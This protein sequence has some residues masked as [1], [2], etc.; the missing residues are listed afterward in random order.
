VALGNALFMLMQEFGDS[1]AGELII[2]VF[3]TYGKQPEVRIVV[4]TIVQLV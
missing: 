4:Y 3:E 2:E 1:G